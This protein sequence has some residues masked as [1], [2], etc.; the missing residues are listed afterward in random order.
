[1][2]DLEDLTALAETAGTDQ[3]D[4][5]DPA[6]LDA[7]ALREAF[8][9]STWA[10]RTPI[11][12]EH[13]VT[14]RIGRLAVRGVIDAVFADPEGTDGQQGVV[15]VDWKTG[16]VPPARQLRELSLQLSLYRLAWHERTGLPLERIRTAFHYVAAGHT[17]EVAEHPSRQ[18]IATMIE[19][20]PRGGA[21]GGPAGT[22]LG[23]D[24]AEGDHRSRD[25]A[26]ARHVRPHH[27][28]IGAAQLLSGLQAGGVDVL[29]D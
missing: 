5:E 26:E 15:I 24:H 21:A 10:A 13:P 20:G 25:P 17:H 8:E 16:R 28:V 14:T 4:Q 27:V 29:H 1:L 22:L 12:V 23:S 3:T 9:A 2:L 19:G 6:D 18:E 7:A 11:A